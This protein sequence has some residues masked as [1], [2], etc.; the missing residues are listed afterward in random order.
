MSSSLHGVAK[1]FPADDCDYNV[2]NVSWSLCIVCIYLER[3]PHKERRYTKKIM[4]MLDIA[5]VYKLF[6]VGNLMLISL[7][8]YY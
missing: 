1:L 8:I 3:K 6:S 7:F 4:H 5:N 2:S